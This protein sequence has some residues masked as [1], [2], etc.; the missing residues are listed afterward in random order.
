MNRHTKVAIFIAP[1]LIVGGYIAADY[2]DKEK[3]KSKN[4]FKLKVQGQCDLSKNPCQLT[5][6]QLTLTLSNNDGITKVISNHSLE[7]ITFSLVDNNHKETAY[8]MN[9][10]TDSNHW[11]ANTKV[12]DL[13]E[14]SSK[15]KLRL[16]ATVNKGFYFSEFYTW[17]D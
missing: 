4:L 7:K 5:N 6:N 1:F 16:I 10:Q 2:Y 15:I 14:H 3:Q 11:Q 8:Q 17:K 9:Y 13:L 12:S